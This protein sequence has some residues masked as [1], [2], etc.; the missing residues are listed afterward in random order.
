MREKKRVF[1]MSYM[2]TCERGGSLSRA[3]ALRY[4][5]LRGLPET[6]EQLAVS[7]KQSP[8]AMRSALCAMPITSTSSS[9]STMQSALNPEP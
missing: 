3:E 4:D 2:P 5:S 8:D 1:Y 6:S 7:S 9:S